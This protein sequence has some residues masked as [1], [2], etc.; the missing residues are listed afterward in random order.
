MAEPPVEFWLSNA[1]VA[2]ALIRQ[3]K[4]RAS[5]GLPNDTWSS[6]HIALMA[7]FVFRGPRTAA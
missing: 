1:Y 6:D 5:T 4:P 7:Q 2:H 3:V